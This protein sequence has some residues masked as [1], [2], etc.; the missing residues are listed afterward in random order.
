[1]NLAAWR[2]LSAIKL[3]R[4]LN[5]VRRLVLPQCNNNYSA[6][7]VSAHLSFKAIIVPAYVIWRRVVSDKIREQARDKKTN[8]ASSGNLHLIG[9]KRSFTS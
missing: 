5:N 1:M 8:I 6:S 2:L 3:Q 9:R 4:Q 7:N